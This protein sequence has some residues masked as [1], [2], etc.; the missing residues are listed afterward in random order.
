MGSFFFLFW[1]C[2]LSFSLLPLLF[3][4]RPNFALLALCRVA[5]G[6][7]FLYSYQLELFTGAVYYLGFLFF[8]PCTI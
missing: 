3:S 2:F 1:A 7:R 4:N 5:M 8:A 6:G